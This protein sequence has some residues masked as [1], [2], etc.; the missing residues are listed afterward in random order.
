MILN[1]VY[2]IQVLR[3][4]IDMYIVANRPKMAGTV[5]VERELCPG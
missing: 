4:S 2:S 1:A 3:W 5:L